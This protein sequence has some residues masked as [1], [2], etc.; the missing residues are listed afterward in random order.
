MPERPKH[1][2]S[3]KPLVSRL[4]AMRDTAKDPDLQPDMPPV[5]GGEYL[6]GYLW[7]VGPVMPGGMGAVVLS[8][9][10]LRAWQESIGF[11]LDPWESRIL[12]RLS[13]DYLAESHKAEKH[14]CPPPWKEADGFVKAVAAK[15]LQESIRAL[16]AL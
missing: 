7:E 13:R 2:K 9:Q 11:E 6:L 4:Q 1:D 5:E 10:E 8:W 3:D 12:R 15:S 14:D 16:A